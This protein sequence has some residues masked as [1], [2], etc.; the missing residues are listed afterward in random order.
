MLASLAGRGLLLYNPSCSKSRAAL[1]LLQKMQADFVV[2]EYLKDPLSTAE[3]KELAGKLHEKPVGWCRVDEP[4]WDVRFSGSDEDTYQALFEYPVLMQR[5]I[6]VRG[7]WAVV[8]R[9]PE[10]VL[11]L[12]G[13]DL[14]MA[15]DQVAAWQEVYRIDTHGSQ[16]RVALAPSLKGAELLADSFEEKRHHQ[17]YFVRPICMPGPVSL[18]SQA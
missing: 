17:G 6:F 2:R 15:S 13:T 8:G 4:E 12:L 3:L 18:R 10:L 7:P 1:V 5:P 11:A 14:P 16:A 9:P